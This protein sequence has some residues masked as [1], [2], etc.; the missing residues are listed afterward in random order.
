MGYVCVGVSCCVGVHC[1]VGVC[2]LCG[3]RVCWGLCAVLGYVC[4]M[5]MCVLG[6]VC[7]VGTCIC[8]GTCAMWAMSIDTSASWPER[9]EEHLGRSLLRGPAWPPDS[10]PHSAEQLTLAFPL[11]VLASLP[12]LLHLLPQAVVTVAF[13]VSVYG[14]CSRE[15]PVRT[16]QSQALGGR[17]AP[18]SGSH[19][20][21]SLALTMV[22]FPVTFMGWDLSI[23]H[24]L[25]C[26]L[27]SFVAV[28][29]L[30]CV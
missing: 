10:Q 13:A 7:C 22:S 27:M 20:T 19:A 3:V 8:W 15:A 14:Q 16:V 21:A 29:L 11:G 17:S 12:V 23:C 28:Q 4:P 25:S 26:P 6:Y 30:S 5:G 1:C 9:R 2:M 24:F 18:F